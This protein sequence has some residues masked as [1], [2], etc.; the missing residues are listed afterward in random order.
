MARRYSPAWE[1]LKKDKKV[2]L[3]TTPAGVRTVIDAVKKE[4]KLDANKPKGY[5][6]SSSIEES[7]DPKFV[8]ITFKLVEDTS[9]RNL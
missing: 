1:R 8:E 4:K 2:V 6:I 3:K 9:I 5:V 7:E